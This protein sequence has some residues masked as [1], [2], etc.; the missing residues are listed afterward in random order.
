MGISCRRHVDVHRG[1]GVSLM[2]IG[3]GGQQP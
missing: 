1:E 2:W 3:K